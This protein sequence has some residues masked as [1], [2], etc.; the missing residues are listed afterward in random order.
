VRKVLIQQASGDYVGMLHVTAAHHRRYAARHDFTFFSIQGD[1]QFERGPHWNKIRLIRSAFDLGF[2]FIAWLDTDTLIVDEEI[3][4]FDGLPE[5]PPIGMC[6]H[7]MAWQSQP[8]HYNSGVILIRNE[9]LSRRFFESVWNAGPVKHPWQEQVRILEAADRFPESVQA[10][11]A[12]WNCTEGSNP[13]SNPVVLAWHGRGQGALPRL[14]GALFHLRQRKSKECEILSAEEI[15]VRK[16]IVGKTYAYRRVGFDERTLALGADGTVTDGAKDC[17]RFWDVREE[18]GQFWLSLYSLHSLTCELRLERDGVWRGKWIDY[19]KMPI[20][21]VPL[22]EKIT[23]A[24]SAVRY[25]NL[26]GAASPR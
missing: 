6:R 23:P 17:E 25:Q 2:D 26:R 22:P 7:P 24:E 13:C 20:E 21:L 1:V 11:D 9:E 15:K 8:W 4:L 12:R 3:S 16:E 19:E 18:C 5:G 10:I 14:K